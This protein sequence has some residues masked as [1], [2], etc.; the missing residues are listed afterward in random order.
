[1]AMDELTTISLTANA[2]DPENAALSYLWE[3]ISGPSAE[4]VNTDSATVSIAAPNV[5][6]DGVMTFRVTVSD[7][8]NVVTQESSVSVNWVGQAL[9]IMAT[10]SS[11]SVMEGASVTLDGSTSVDPDGYPLSYQWSQVSGPTVSLTT[12]MSATSGFT[13]P[14]VSSDSA[15]VIRLTISQGNREISTDT[16]IT[17]KNQVT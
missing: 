7:G 16:S 8:V 15:V 10:A 6:Q 4:L 11:T 12:P 3:Q 14:Q 5:T 1:A 2:L 9:S 13:A 17:V